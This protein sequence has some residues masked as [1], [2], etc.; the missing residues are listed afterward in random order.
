MTPERLEELE[1]QLQSA[2]SEHENLCCAGT[3][4]GWQGRV[5]ELIA[6]YR[7]ADR[8]ALDL[9]QA[10]GVAYQLGV[11]AGKQAASSAPLGRP[12]EPEEPTRKPPRHAPNCIR[13]DGEWICSGDC[14]ADP[15]WSGLRDADPNVHRR[16]AER[17]RADWREAQQGISWLRGRVRFLEAEL[18]NATESAAKNWALYD[19]TRAE[20][21]ALRSANVSLASAGSQLLGAIEERDGILRDYQIEGDTS[22]RDIV[23][24]TT[25]AACTFR[26]EL[27]AA[28]S[29][30]A[31]L[32][33]A[34]P[35]CQH[36]PNP[37]TYA[38]HGGDELAC[39][40]HFPETQ[41]HSSGY[42]LPYAPALRALGSKR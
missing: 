19:E 32:C 7:A 42:G 41:R 20:L 30:L 18:A 35:R 15:D 9:F 4:L 39:D 2:G 22:V 17:A 24:R 33:S 1:R 13:S 40:E 14:T 37:A 38:W 8:A 10:N 5:R 34:L 23:E 16:A 31:K 29:D 3:R 6:A 11:E 25:R 21:E 36:C 28:R 12:I 26:D 27:T